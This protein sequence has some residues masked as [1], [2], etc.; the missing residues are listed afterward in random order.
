[1]RIAVRIV[2]LICLGLHLFFIML[3]GAASG[4]SDS[5]SSAS[6]KTLVLLGS[7]FVCFGYCL[8]SSFGRWRGHSLLIGGIAA[9][10]IMLPFVIRL[11]RDGVPFFAL[12]VLLMA[13]CWIGMYLESSA[14]TDA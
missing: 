9:H 13:L 2:S 4:L 11:F 6:N 1:M 10:L 7:P 8:L 5:S 3:L 12:P 14:K